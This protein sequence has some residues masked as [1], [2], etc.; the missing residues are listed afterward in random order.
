MQLLFLCPVIAVTNNNVSHADRKQLQQPLIMG[1]RSVQKHGASLRAVIRLAELRKK[2]RRWPA[3]LMGDSKAFLH[4]R[5]IA[6]M[7]P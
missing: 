7:L 4:Q 5:T 1:D 2:Q 3:W 6:V